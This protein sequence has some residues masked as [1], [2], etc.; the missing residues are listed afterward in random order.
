MKAL[1]VAGAA[2]LLAFTA[3]CG[4]GSKPGPAYQ[5]A[6]ACKL[7]ASATRLSQESNGL[8]G[9]G[10]GYLAQATVTIQQDKGHLSPSFRRDVLAVI[11]TGLNDPSA[12]AVG[13]LGNDCTR[14][15]VRSAIWPASLTGS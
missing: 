4:G 9:G 8:S 3:S 5:D 12:A 11:G 15:G 13:Q 14:L 1:I 7:L 10:F 2:L 6:T